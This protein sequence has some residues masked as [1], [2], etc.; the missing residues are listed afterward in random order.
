ML[1]IIF[2]IADCMKTYVFLQSVVTHW[3][4]SIYN[5]IKHEKVFG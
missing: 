4:I 3:F 2:A 1:F 5:N